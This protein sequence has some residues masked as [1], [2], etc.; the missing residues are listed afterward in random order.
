[1]GKSRGRGKS[2]V[3]SLRGEIRQL[4]KELKYYKRRSHIEN[5]IIDDVIEDSDLEIVN[6]SDCPSCG[7]GVLV[8][9]DFIYA[10]LQKCACGFEI[11]KRKS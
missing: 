2:E 10:T 9:Y 5:S 11:K 8:E 7:K 1:M 6:T 3:E 4:K